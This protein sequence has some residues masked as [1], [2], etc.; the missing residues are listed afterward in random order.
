MLEQKAVSGV[1]WTTLATVYKAVLQLVQLAFVAHLLSAKDIGLYALL[2]IIFAFAIL[3]FDM[4]IGPAVVHYQNVSRGR[5]KQLGAVNLL[6]ALI[7]TIAVAALS[8]LIA[9]LFNAPELVPA[10]QLFSLTFL[11]LGVS[12]LNLSTLQKQL[13]FTSIALA[14]IFAFS[15]GFATTL[16]LIFSG[17]GIWGLIYG[18]MLQ[19]ALLSLAYLYFTEFAFYFALPKSFRKLKKYINYGAFKSMDAVVNY[20]NSQIDLI[21]V[22]KLLGTEVLGGYNLIRQFCFRPAMVINPVITRVAFPYMAK[23]QKSDTLSTSYRSMLNLL[24][25]INFPLYLGFAVFADPIVDIMFGERWGH[26]VPLLQILSVWCLIRSVFNPVGSLMMAI[27]KVKLLWQWNSALLFLFPIAL[28]FSSQFG[29]LGV[30]LCLVILQLAVLP[31]HWWLLLNKTINLTFKQFMKS[32]YQPLLY[33]LL[34]ALCVS[35]LHYFNDTLPSWS[36]LGIGGLMGAGIYVAL[37]ARLKSDAYLAI[38]H[39]TLLKSR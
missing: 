38:R 21:V 26:L 4:G 24:A 28:I 19:Q 7:L 6:I 11:I 31:G 34:T 25:S 18:F 1:K 20:F 29:L 10:L 35:P 22:A 13:S 15:V 33:A 39:K 2:Q 23:L 36:L 32:V 17:K 37:N 8:P 27:G 12:R 16:Y 30:A 5:L 3:I 14:E 9:L